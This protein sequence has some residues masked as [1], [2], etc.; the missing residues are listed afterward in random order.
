MRNLSTMAALAVTAT[1][2]TAACAQWK[3]AEG[4]L[5]TKWAADVSPDNVRG[6]YPRPQMVRKD[7]RNLNGLW[8][9]AIRPRQEGQ[10]Q[11][12]DGQI[13]V[14]FAIESALS[15]V[16]KTVG[17]SNRLWY[18]RTFDNPTKSG[19]RLLLHFEASDWRTTVYVNGQEVGEHTGGYTPFAFDITDKVKGGRNELVVSVWDP[20]DGGYQPRGKQVRNPEGIW[21]TSVTGIWG[22][23]WLEPVNASHI[24]SVKVTP[25]VDGGAVKVEVTARSAG[26]TTGLAITVKDGSSTVATAEVQ[27]AGQA[28]GRVSASATVRVPNAKPWSPDSPHLYG[29]T[30]A[31]TV[32]GKTT[33]EVESYFGMR[34]I[35]IR[36]DPVDGF[37]RLYLNGAA[38]FQ[39]GPLDQ[40]WWPDGLYTAPTDEALRY[41]IEVTRQLGFNMARKHVKVEPRRWYYWADKLGLLVWQDMPN[42][43]RHIGSN[44]PDITR[45][46]E[47]AANYER[48]WKAIM[49]TLHNHP[50]IVVWV[51]FNEG[52]GQF[53][54]HRILAW[55]KQ[56]DPTRLVDG[57]SGWTDRGSGD[58]HDMHNYPGPNMPKPEPVRAVV[59]GEFGGLGLPL[60]QHLW[61]NKRNWG[62]RTYKTTQELQSNYTQLIVRLRPLISRGLAAA[63][64]TQ[65]TDVE[66]EVNGLLTYD[67][68]V[69]K[70]DAQMLRKL[71][72]PLYG[73]PPI[74]EHVMVEATSEAE[75]RQWRYTTDK[76]ADGWEKADFDDAAW[77]A[78]PG[79]FGE[80]STPGSVVRTDWK[81]PDIWMRR[82]FEVAKAD[83]G[84]LHVRIHH[85]E[86]AQ[87][88]LNGQ[89]I[90][91]VQGYTT[92]YVELP[93]DEKLRGALK[94]GKNVL[95]VHCRQTGGGQ[96]I[97]LG[98]VR[99]IE[100][101]RPAAGQ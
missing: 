72:E 18:R 7:W 30:I 5:F 98:L 53:D 58:M 39:F 85:D 35:E 79:G 25:D 63:V 33:D 27:V 82:T 87:V 34:K 101:P 41:D 48:E 45:T 89:L 13:L 49:D 3:P 31:Q 81:T 37:N 9:Y 91:S 19:Q 17:E 6:E 32:G 20:T 55:T 80:R 4:P 57:P 74:I 12:W 71:H 24:E 68:A 2:S 59:L 90:A 64:Y 70:L 61:W 10:P 40:G 15:G 46:A 43:D 93:V 73:P 47:S 99:V 22:T 42:G 88:Y 97:D 100:K 77:K 1:M 67:R 83:A 26:E 62:Y 75:G 50:C 14:P 21:Y 86:D 44:D 29:L 51:P 56:Y 60:E 84:G 94:S 76:P 16:K 78:G 36:K 95:A 38:L 69:V 23:V 66:G 52:W 11:A 54:T 65:T 92:D 28:A 96:Y 8:E